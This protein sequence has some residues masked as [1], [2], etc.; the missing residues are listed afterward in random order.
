MMEIT[1]VHMEKKQ[2]SEKWL[3]K[4]TFEVDSINEIIEINKAL[5]FKR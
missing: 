4:V 5:N 1:E 3:L 2:F